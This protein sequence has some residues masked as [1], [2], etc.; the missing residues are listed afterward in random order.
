MLFVDSEPMEVVCMSDGD[1]VVVRQSGEGI[2]VAGVQLGTG[3]DAERRM[4]AKGSGAAQNGCD[5]W[6]L[7]LRAS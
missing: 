4:T 7:V 2:K 6:V 3:D 5:Q 1:T